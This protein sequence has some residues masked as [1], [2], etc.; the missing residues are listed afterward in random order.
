[1]TAKN[2]K[3]ASKR[4]PI[5]PRRDHIPV[6]D[7]TV[8]AGK[9]LLLF[10]IPAT[11]FL[12]GL[13]HFIS[14]SPYAWTDFPLD[15]AWIHRVYARAFAFAQGFAYNPGQQETGATSPLWAIV[16][17]PVHW[18]EF[19]V[20]AAAGVKILT[21]FIGLGC[22]FLVARISLRAT[23]S[24]AAG[25]AA[26]AL[27]ALEPRFLFS[28]L[29]GMETI[30]FLALALGCILAILERR[31]TAA[32][33]CAGLAVLARPEA[34]LFLPFHYLLLFLEAKKDRRL[35]KFSL[36]LLP[37]LPGLI[38]SAYCLAVSGRP[39]PA[40]FYLKAEQIRLGGLAMRDALRIVT[41]QGFGSIILLLPGLAVSAL[42]VIL[43]KKG[44][45]GIPLM[46][47]FA[48]PL[49]LAIATASSRILDPGGYYWTRYLD[50]PALLLSVACCIGLVLPFAL[51]FRPSLLAG[52]VGDPGKRRI[53]TYIA[54]A[55]L[56]CLVILA[57]PGFV[58]SWE[59]RRGHLWTDSRAIHLVNVRAGE[60]ID[61]NVPAGATVGVNDAGA[62][63]YFGNRVTIDLKGLN[64]ADLAYD[65]VSHEAVIARTDWLAVFPSWFRGTNLFDFYE[66]R[67]SFSI[68]LEEYTVC[69]CP[70]QTEKVIYKKKS[71]T[72]NTR[73]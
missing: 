71:G 63:R 20:P 61:A 47:L 19:L 59:D 14:A 38:W 1:M 18:L 58:R 60:W 15:D 36:W 6:P 2:T 43:R 69:D 40:T 28:V 45:S 66:Q 51:A 44:R 24:I 32:S 64:Y 68:P 37:V 41:E 11:V 57:A 27:F 22:L 50:P 3:G 21:A 26:A 62:I 25:I 73:P 42:W 72:V 56:A 23:G 29:S 54:A 65:R 67:H 53:G 31:W 4:K 49:V 33:I 39:L 10:L 46:L 30:P 17:A 55:V 52:M 7:E 34:V 12:A 48:F 9:E 70:G 5:A 35:R 13:W 8:A 16:S